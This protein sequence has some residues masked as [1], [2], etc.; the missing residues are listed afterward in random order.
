MKT[1]YDYKTIE[2]LAR[3]Y[4]QGNAKQKR[5]IKHD[6]KELHPELWELVE[7]EVHNKLERRNKNER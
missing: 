2:K 6:M 1:F 4:C 5:T 3:Y 7:K